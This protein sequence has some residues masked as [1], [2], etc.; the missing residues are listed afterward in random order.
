MVSDLDDLYEQEKLKKGPSRQ[1]YDVEVQQMYNSL[2]ERLKA[3]EDKNTLKG[4]NPD[5]LILVLNLIIPPKFKTP[6]FEKY[7][8]PT[9]HEAHLVTYCC[10]MVGHT[11]NEKLLIHVFQY[12]LTE[13][14]LKWY[15]KLRRNQICTWRDIARAFLEQF[16]YML[17]TV[18]D[19][20]TLQ[21]MEKKSGE[22]YRKY[23]IRWMVVVSQV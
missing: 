21:S 17:E 16:K 13:V 12:S 19:H 4:V 7:E 8:R 23:A 18:P 6:L 3:V 11:Y 10:K 20:F 22:S 5:E 14:A 2:E 1:S 9:C 15:L